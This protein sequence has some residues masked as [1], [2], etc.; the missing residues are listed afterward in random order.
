MLSTYISSNPEFNLPVGVQD[1]NVDVLRSALDKWIVKTELRINKTE[2]ALGNKLEGLDEDGDGEISLQEVESFAQKILKHPNRKAAVEFM[3]MIDRDK[4]GVVS[5]V[6]LLKYIEE[7]KE[8]LEEE[9][10]LEVLP[11]DS[12]SSSAAHHLLSCV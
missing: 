8:I 10:S 6:E 5:V 2:E 1:K 4:D 12:F 9:G 3:N 11:Y 7:R